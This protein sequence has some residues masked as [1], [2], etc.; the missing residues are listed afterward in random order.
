MVES[1]TLI[2]SDR[3]T[4]HLPISLLRDQRAQLLAVSKSPLSYEKQSRAVRACS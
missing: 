2:G 1:Q 4:L 3:I